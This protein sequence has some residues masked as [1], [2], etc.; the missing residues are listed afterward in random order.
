MEIK[1]WLQAYQK[2]ICVFLACLLLAIGAV[3]GR[4]FLSDNNV[5]LTASEAANQ[6][7][8]FLD[9]T[10]QTQV[11]ESSQQSVTMTVLYVD[12]KGA[13]ARPGVYQMTTGDRVYDVINKAGGLTKEACDWLI[14]GAQ[15]VADQQFIYILTKAEAKEQAQEPVVTRPE[16][17]PAVAS[18]SPETP[19]EEGKVNINTA[20]IAQLTTL[21][22]IGQ[23]KAEAIISYRE[24]NGPF[25]ALE[26]LKEVSGIG[27]KTVEKLRSSIT[28]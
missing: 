5:P 7:V 16:T 14:N 18:G 8:G 19:T 20:D 21:S 17:E 2:P 15:L 25:K 12:I 27:E 26:D 13:V 22:G 10:S 1:E 24:E 4:L 9:E 3:C 6:G 23:K 11:A 28:I